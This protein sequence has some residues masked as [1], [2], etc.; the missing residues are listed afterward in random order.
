[1]SGEAAPGWLVRIERAGNRLPEPAVLFAAGWGLVLIA[2][3]LAE[4]AGLAV[5]RP[6]K[7]RAVAGAMVD[8]FES[9]DVDARTFKT[10]IGS[11][12]TIH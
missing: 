11:G 4:M 2:S 12:A 10:M 3:Q 6:G 9:I 8:A 7:R 1:M 5:T